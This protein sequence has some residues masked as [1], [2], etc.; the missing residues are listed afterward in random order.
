[1]ND[2]IL[3]VSSGN[4]LPGADSAQDSVRDTADGQNAGEPV[5]DNGGDSLG[6]VDTTLTGLY[7]EDLG[8]V[9]V[10]IVSDQRESE[11]DLYAV[12]G[13]MGYQVS[14]YWLNY[15]KGVLANVGDVDYCIFS[16]REYWSGS[17][18]LQHY[19]LFYGA[20]MGE[21]SFQPGTYTCYDVY[22]QNSI[23]YV[24]ISQEYFSGVEAGKLVYSNLPGYSDI[25]EGVTYDVAWTVL[26]FLGFFA[27]YTVCHDIFDYIMY[28]IYRR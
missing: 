24:N 20:D 21:D 6:D 15:F 18:T 8:G 28:R 16:T 5:V 4:A 2:D 7:D 26:F 23:Y 9:P 17:S 19:Y 3:S 1:M 14:D 22:S 13:T 27:V 12:S 25:R 11:V 10:V